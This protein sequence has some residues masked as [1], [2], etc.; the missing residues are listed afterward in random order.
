MTAKLNIL[1]ILI[2]CVVISFAIIGGHYGISLLYGKDY[3]LAY[4]PFVILCVATLFSSLGTIASRFIAKY[5]GYSYLSKKAFC[6]L[7]LSIMLNV[8]FINLWG[9]IGAAIATLATEFI[10]LT[11][12][13]Y[14]FKDG[15][16]LKLHAYKIFY[17]G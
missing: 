4:T 9:I 15:I 1:V 6:V 7:I 5:S 16:V 3:V 14:L 2:G 11:L 8:I 12:L 17:R 13:N 10:S